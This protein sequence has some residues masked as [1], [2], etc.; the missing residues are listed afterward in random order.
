[1][2]KREK[3]RTATVDGVDVILLTPGQHAGLESARRQLGGAQAHVARLRLD[4]RRSQELL[5][6]VERVL[7]HLPVGQV[8]P[9]GGPL[10]E[11]RGIADLLADIRA[12]LPHT[13]ASEKRP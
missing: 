6:E 1:M 13:P 8:E 9:A 12:L 5:G 3:P 2:T 11:G 4:L 10:A 7:A